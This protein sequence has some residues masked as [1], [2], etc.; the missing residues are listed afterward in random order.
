MVRDL[1]SQKLS[2]RNKITCPSCWNEFPPEEIHWV[3]KHPS[4]APDPI[5]GTGE[6]IRFLPTRFSI[7]GMAIDSEGLDCE[8]LACPRCHLTVPRALLEIKPMIVSILGAPSSGKS[9]YLAAMTWQL[10]TTL[11]SKY[12]VDFSDADPVANLI[13]VEYEELLFHNQRDDIPITLRKTESYD[14]YTN[15]T[16]T[17]D[18]RDL[19]LPKPFVFR[20]A[21]LSNHPHY[22]AGIRLSRAMCLYD[23]AGED[24]LPQNESN[25]NINTDHL[26]VSNV[27]LFL[28]DPTQHRNVKRQLQ[29][30]SSDP[31]VGSAVTSYRQDQVLNHAANKI[32]NQTALGQDRQT[33]RPLVITVTKFDVWRPLVDDSIN[34]LMEDVSH[35]FKKNVAALNMTKLRK[36]SALVREFLNEY[37]VEVVAA[38]EGFS[39][40]V[41]YIPVSAIGVDCRPVLNADTGKFDVLPRDIAP[42]WTDIPMLYAMHQCS[43]GLIRS[44]TESNDEDKQGTEI[45]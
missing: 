6:Q 10:R 29:G 25:R 17:I 11:H 36:V 19:T 23:N 12:A 20:L 39:S 24:F 30:Q 22:D 3:S 4:L 28:F 7:K 33:D 31:Q 13:L 44:G 2:L 16:V 42:L 14:G 41:I 40:D 27:L 38:A 18:N 26:G 34:Q 8:R 35:K 5:L 9:Y 45:G 32:R 37:A 15:Q 43:N 21:S 1:G